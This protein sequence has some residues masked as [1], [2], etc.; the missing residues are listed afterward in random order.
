VSDVQGKDGVRVPSDRL[1]SVDEV[2]YFL[3][4]PVATLYQWKCEGRGP[5]SRRVGRYLRYR[6]ADVHAWLDGLDV[7]GAA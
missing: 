5:K 7:S 1:W 3:G 6:P 2:S 4:I